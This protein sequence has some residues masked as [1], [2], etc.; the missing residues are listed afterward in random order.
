M[1]VVS[2]LLRFGGFNP[3]S[4][5]WLQDPLSEV[6]SLLAYILLIVYFIRATKK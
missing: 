2:A 5:S 6:C 1:G 4:E 3:V